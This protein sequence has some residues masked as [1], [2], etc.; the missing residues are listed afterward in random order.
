MSD[1][2]DYTE[3]SND[4]G[5]ENE[6]DVDSEDE[7]LLG[8]HDQPLHLHRH[9]SKAVT[10]QNEMVR[11]CLALNLVPDGTPTLIDIPCNKSPACQSAGKQGFAYKSLCC[12]IEVC[13]S[14]EKTVFFKVCGVGS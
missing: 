14:E 1:Q 10:F 2:K 11:S 8:Q 7:M 3:G 9:R 13:A 12:Y 5:E 4:G 6:Q